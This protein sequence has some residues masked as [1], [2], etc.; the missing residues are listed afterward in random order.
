[1]TK[2]LIAFLMVLML[3]ISV[4]SM[5]LGIGIFEER[6]NWSTQGPIYAPAGG[7]TGPGCKVNNIVTMLK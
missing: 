1:M 5:A 4:A 2:R 6:G 3:A 7:R